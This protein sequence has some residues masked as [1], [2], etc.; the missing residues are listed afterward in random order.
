MKRF[1]AAIRRLRTRPAAQSPLPTAMA[2]L[3]PKAAAAVRQAL[4]DA[5]ARDNIGNRVA[6]GP[7]S[8]G[9]ADML[10]D[11]P[12]P[13]NADARDPLAPVIPVD[14]ASAR[15]GD[16]AVFADHTAIVADNGQL[17]GPSGQEHPAGPGFQG[18]YRPS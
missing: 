12:Q 7:I 5:E 10:W 6:I 9:A 16:I 3:N 2:A 8:R 18:I 4:V 14:P 15:P 11:E 1:L 13:R 17:I